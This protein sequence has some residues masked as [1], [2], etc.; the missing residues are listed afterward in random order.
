[1][2]SVVLVVNSDPTYLCTNTHTHL[3]LEYRSTQWNEDIVFLYTYTTHFVCDVHVMYVGG[4]LSYYDMIW[5]FVHNLL[6]K[7]QIS[8]GRRS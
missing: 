3:L 2:S 1:M 6:L 5:L 4:S 8:Y 7:K